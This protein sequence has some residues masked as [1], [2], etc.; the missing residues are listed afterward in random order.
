MRGQ[1]QPPINRKV[2]YY[3]PAPQQLLYFLPLPQV[4]G[5]LGATFFFGFVS[6]AFLATEAV[7]SVR[8]MMIPFLAMIKGSD[9][10]KHGYY[11]P[12]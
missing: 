5:S 1:R 11:I 4:Q 2:V 9:A 3:F 7:I 12:K 8:F 6:R 10:V